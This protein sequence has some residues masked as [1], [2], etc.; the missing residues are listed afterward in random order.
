[1]KHFLQDILW[2]LLFGCVVI[3]P[4]EIISVGKQDPLAYQHS[5]MDANPSRIKTLVLGH[6]QTANAFNTHEL[7]DSAFCAATPS[8]VIYFDLLL[9]RKYIDRLPNLKAVIYPMHYSFENACLFYSNQGMQEVITYR[10]AKYMRLHTDRYPTIW[11]LSKSAFLSGQLR[12]GNLTIDDNTDSLGYAPWK[13]GATGWRSEDDVKQIRQ[14]EFTRDLTEMARLCHEQGVRL[15]VITCPFSNAALEHVTEE[16][17][18]NMYDVV[19]RVN[20]RYPIE[21]R[22]YLAAPNLR[23]DSL[24]HDWSHLD[25]HGATLFA[26]QVKKDF[27]L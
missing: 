5:Y 15:I 3:L 6:S 1:M 17:V 4:G 7:G 26:N 12:V 14:E 13:G 19:E 10:H 27:G 16:G 21:Y 22:S 25:R 2:T 20:K 11:F 8:R 24:Y 9:L 18:K 23:D